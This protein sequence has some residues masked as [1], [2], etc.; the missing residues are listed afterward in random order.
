MANINIRVEGTNEEIAAVE[1]AFVAAGGLIAEN[2]IRYGD[3]IDV[4][5]QDSATAAT[6]AAAIVTAGNATS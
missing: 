5:T 4:V 6:I 2:F 1:A 3:R